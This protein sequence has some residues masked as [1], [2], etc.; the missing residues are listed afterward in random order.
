MFNLAV[1]VRTVGAVW[2][3]LPA[4][5]EAAAATLGASPWR[6]FREITLPLLRPAILAAASIVFV[7]TFTSFGVIRVLGDVG[8]STIEVEIWRQATQ[9][10]DI[11]AAATLA[12]LQLVAIGAGVAWSA[13]QQRRHSRALALRPADPAAATPAAAVSAASSSPSPLSTAVVVVA[14]LVALVE[15]SLRGGDGYSLAAWRDLGRAEVRPGIRVGVD[16]LAAIADVAAHDRRGDGDRRRR[17]ASS[18]RSRSPPPGAAAGCS[19]PA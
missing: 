9:L 11:G 12:V 1:V 19:T 15:R 17:S 10:G 14:P 8:T 3:H 6:A 18:P 2:D 7:F 16:P 13:R 5:L 4:D